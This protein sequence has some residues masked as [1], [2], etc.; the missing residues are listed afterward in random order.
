MGQHLQQQV[1]GDGA[2]EQGLAQRY[3]FSSIGRS[4]RFSFVFEVISSSQGPHSHL[5]R[6]ERVQVHFGQTVSERV[7]R[8]GSRMRR[9]RTGT[10]RAFISGQH[11]FK[12]MRTLV[13][14]PA[15]ELDGVARVLSLLR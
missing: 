6:S 5:M 12:V 7:A 14:D 15:M 1:A 4:S 10:L 11:T 9:V 2:A 8:P 3:P 13:K